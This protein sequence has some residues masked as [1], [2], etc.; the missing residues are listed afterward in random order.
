M[1]SPFSCLALVLAALLPSAA[2]AQ[3]PSSAALDSTSRRCLAIDWLDASATCEGRVRNAAGLSIVG[4]GAGAL[5]GFAGGAVSPT[6]CLGYAEKSA[7]RG[8]IAGAAL[9][10]IA[11]LVTRHI[12]RHERAAR[13]ARGRDAAQRA[14]ARPW[15]WR[16]VRP[17]AVALGAVAVT[18]AVIGGV[19]GNRS[20][21]PCSGGVAGGM[22]TG[23]GTYAAGGA[24][25]VLGTMLVVRFLF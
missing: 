1:R 3:R 8:A 5:A 11:G 22:A 9:G 14:P 23:A 7:V 6:R 20:P 10:G 24:T 19:Q 16:D 2:Q 21:S 12:S 18:G 25:T 13:D 15:S 4:A 17:A